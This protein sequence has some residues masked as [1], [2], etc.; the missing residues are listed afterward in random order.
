MA[1]TIYYASVRM[2]ELVGTMPQKINP[3]SMHL[4]VVKILIAIRLS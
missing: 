3:L 2:P 4:D 1:N